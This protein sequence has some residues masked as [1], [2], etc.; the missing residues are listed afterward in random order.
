[1]PGGVIS[2]GPAAGS[3]LALSG[4]QGTNAAIAKLPEPLVKY[5]R[6]DVPELSL[7]ASGPP[8]KKARK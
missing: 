6:T 2:S 8:M 5:L 7:K 4:T 1:M 3:Q